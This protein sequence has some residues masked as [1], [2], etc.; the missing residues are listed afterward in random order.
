MILR[1]EPPSSPWSGWMRSAGAW[2]CF[3]KSLFSTSMKWLPA[4]LDSQQ[5]QNRLFSII[6]VCRGRHSIAGELLFLLIGIECNL[7]EALPW[8]AEAPLHFRDAHTQGGEKP[9]PAA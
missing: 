5:K 8:R 1:R 2:K 4:H 9:S 6:A 7:C 3:S